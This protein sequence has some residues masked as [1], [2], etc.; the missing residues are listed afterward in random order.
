MLD[1]KV[2]ALYEQICWKSAFLKGVG[3]FRPNF[4][5]EGDVPHEQF[6]QGYMGQR[7]PY[8]SIA[9]SICTKK[10]YSRLSSSEVHFLPENGHFAFLGLPPFGGLQATYAVRLGLIGKLVENSL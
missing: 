7:M 2:E 4:H 3:P 9:D 1:V 8:N 10:V 6:L 5:V